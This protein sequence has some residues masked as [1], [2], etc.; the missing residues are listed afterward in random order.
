MD[1]G[2]VNIKKETV[3]QFDFQNLDDSTRKLMEEEINN[4]IE[5]ENL[6]SS[7]SFTQ[8]GIEKWPNLLKQAAQEYDEQWLASELLKQRLFLRNKQTK[9][10]HTKIA[11]G[12][13]NR[14]YMIAVCRKAIEEGYDNVTVYRAHPSIQ[15][16]GT[17]KRLIGQ[18]INA[19]QLIQDIRPLT[20]EMH[21]HPL[22]Q[23]NSGISVKY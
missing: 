22:A 4:A 18:Q 21:R 11:E 15:P 19:E 9:D 3:M 1:R 17:S 16:R 5:E 14:Y 6:Y 12:Q 23:A 10:S 7:K 20:N 13:F 8:E 2:V